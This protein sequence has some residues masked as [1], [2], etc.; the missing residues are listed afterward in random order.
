MQPGKPKSNRPL[1][2][3]RTYQPDAK[4]ERGFAG[5]KVL[6]AKTQNFPCRWENHEWTENRASAADNLRKISP[7]CVGS[8]KFFLHCCPRT[9]NSIFVSFTA[10]S[11][12]NYYFFSCKIWSPKKG[13]MPGAHVGFLRASW[14]V[15]ACSKTAAVVRVQCSCV[16]RYERE[17]IRERQRS[18]IRLWS[19]WANGLTGHKIAN[20]YGAPRPPMTDVGTETAFRLDQRKA[21]PKK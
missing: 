14:H 1:R 17:V 4:L 3:Y 8:E 10:F 7:S 15:R 19:P 11:H 21:F 16:P 9:K 6:R 5:G 13:S 20:R 18:N 12:E 2:T